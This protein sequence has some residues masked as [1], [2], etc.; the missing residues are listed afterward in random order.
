LGPGDQVTMH[1]KESGAAREYA[2]ERIATDIDI[3]PQKPRRSPNPFGR[4]TP[5][6]PGGG[7]AKSRFASIKPPTRASLSVAGAAVD[8]A[9]RVR[10]VSL[11]HP[12]PDSV[13]TGPVEDFSDFEG[14]YRW[15]GHPVSAMEDTDGRP[16]FVAASL[17]CCPVFRDWTQE[18]LEAEF[19]AGVDAGIIHV[20]GREITPSSVYEIQLVDVTCPDLTQE[21][22]YSEA[23]VVETGHWADIVAPFASS[24]SRNGQN[25]FTDIAAV[26]DA[27]VAGEFAPIKAQA[28][29]RGSMPPIHL[30]INFTD[31]ATAV[32]A[33]TGVPYIGEMFDCTCDPDWCCPACASCE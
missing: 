2:V 25:D 19:G 9:I 30:Q 27:F 33:F 23:L 26:V 16:G 7:V 29:L 22:C 10:L 1:D 20:F 13:W 8:Q 12:P 3:V 18:A 14:R 32:D 17:Q 11:N 4:E 24:E 6:D 31:I 5:S 15:L 28:M 21:S